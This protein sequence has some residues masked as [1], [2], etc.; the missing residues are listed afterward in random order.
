MYVDLVEFKEGVG[1]DSSLMIPEELKK[2][3]PEEDELMRYLRILY[4]I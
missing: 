4:A 2:Y 1:R 3:I